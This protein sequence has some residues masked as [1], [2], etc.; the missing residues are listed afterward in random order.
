MNLESWIMKLNIKYFGMLA[1]LTQ[2]SE[3]TMVVE[4]TT[5]DELLEQL[6]DKYPGLQEKDFQVAQDQ[7][8]VLKENNITASELALLPPFSGG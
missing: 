4:A 5:I 3:E 8:I 1:E 7:Q 2:C 6:F